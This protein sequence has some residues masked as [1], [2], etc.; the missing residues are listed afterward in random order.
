MSFYPTSIPRCQH[1][2]VNGTQCGS[3]ALHRRRF[4]FFHHQWRQERISIGA[5]RARQGR[6]FDLPV[7]EDANAIQITLMQ[8]MRLIL[9]GQ[10]DPKSAGLL[11]YA[12]QTASVNLRN[13]Q[14]EPRPQTPVV[15]DPRDVPA[16]PLDEDQWDPDDFEEEEELEEQDTE[17]DGEEEAAEGQVADQQAEEQA[18]AT[19]ELK[20][21]ATEPQAEDENFES[22]T[23]A[24]EPNEPR[25]DGCPHPSGRGATCRGSSASSATNPGSTQQAHT[26][27]QQPTMSLDHKK[28]SASTQAP[29]ANDKRQRTS[30]QTQPRWYAPD[31]TPVTD[32]KLDQL[33]MLT[34]FLDYL[35]PLPPGEEE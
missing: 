13:T 21:V 15:L 30:D 20:A 28:P 32:S 6:A 4:C 25:G 7:L 16:T 31:G 34:Q 27:P 29:A 10:I 3:P 24:S 14:F 23:E 17:D 9:R 22:Q 11:L 8:I 2:K 35:A 26:P 1:I 18:A 12:L 33:R 19:N 5:K